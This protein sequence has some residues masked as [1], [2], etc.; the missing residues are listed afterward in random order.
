MPRTTATQGRTR[1]RTWRSRSAGSGCRRSR[2][3]GW[4]RSCRWRASRYTSGDSVLQLAAHVDRLSESDL[5]VALDRRPDRAGASGRAVRLG[6][7]GES[8]AN[9]RAGGDGAPTMLPC[10][11]VAWRSGCCV[12]ACSLGSPG[13]QCAPRLEPNIVPGC[14]SG[15]TGGP[16]RGARSRGSIGRRPR[17][18]TRGDTCVRDR[19]ARGGGGPLEQVATTK[20]I[21]ALIHPGNGRRDHLIRDAE[22][23]EWQVLQVQPESL[24][25]NA[26]AVVEEPVGRAVVGERGEPHGR[27]RSLLDRRRCSGP[28]HPRCDPAR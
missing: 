8:P 18:L 4:D 28:A 19:D 9:R 10:L 20:A 2:A 22:L 5:C 11:R 14:A 1:S 25:G 3:S 17:V 12:E 16:A 15:P 23:V 21:R 27:V 24:P 7:C 6:R 13:P 26:L